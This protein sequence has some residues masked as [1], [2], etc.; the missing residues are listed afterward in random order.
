MAW[1]SVLALIGWV[2]AGPVAI[3]VM[4]FFVQQDATR[5]ADPNYL[6]QPNMNVY[7]FGAALSAVV[8]IVVTAISAAF[9]VGHL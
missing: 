4:A 8:G 2:L 6:V 7:Y 1:D 5:R 3:G 9:W